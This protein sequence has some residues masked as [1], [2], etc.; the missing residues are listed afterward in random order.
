VRPIA[1]ASTRRSTLMPELP[2]LASFYPGF[3]ADN[4]YAMF[5]PGSVSRDIVAKLYSEVAKA[6]QAPDMRDTIIKDGAE[7]VGSTPDELAAYFRKEVE[8]YAKVIKAA[9]ITSE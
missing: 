8:K 9:K 7:P 6:V 5:A 2:T 4:W 3:D 1:V